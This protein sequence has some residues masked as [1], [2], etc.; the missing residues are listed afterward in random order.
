[1]VLCD[2]LTVGIPAD[3][4]IYTRQ[5]M[6]LTD[7]AQKFPI[8][9]RPGYS[10]S[11]VIS[12]ATASQVAATGAL[13]T[14]SGGTT[15]F[16]RTHP[17]VIIGIPKNPMVSVL[18]IGDSITGGVGDTADTFANLGYISRGLAN[19]NGHAVPWHNQGVNGLAMTSQKLAT[20][21]AFRDVWQ[22]CTHALFA[23]GYNDMNA[24]S[25][26]V[27]QANALAVLQELKRTIG[28]YGKPL[29]VTVV[30][31]IPAT[32][33]T[34]GWINAAGQTATANFA[35]GA[36][37]DQYNA[38]LLSLVGGGLVDAAIDISTVTDDPA[39]LGKWFTN[40][41]ANF[42]TVD[43]THPA[44]GMATRMAGLITTWAQTSKP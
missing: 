31:I 24:S 1:M 26:S 12:P 7:P 18:A 33:S 41:T 38:W 9:L 36:K 44:Q 29:H 27:M 28:P 2:P 30:T 17:S 8:D 15:A 4:V 35:P 11:N 3:S 23:M 14:P 21:P 20:S 43:G 34:N 40:G 16:A 25:L 42:P 37:R 13:T 5:S 10:G 22:Y 19:V 39:N 6:T 32:T